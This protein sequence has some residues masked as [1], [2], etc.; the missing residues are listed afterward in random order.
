MGSCPPGKLERRPGREA[1]LRWEAFQVLNPLKA[2]AAHLSDRAGDASLGARYPGE[3]AVSGVPV[4]GLQSAGASD[5]RDAPPSLALAA[6][7]CTSIVSILT[8]RP[9]RM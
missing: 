4:G 8:K 3:G 1:G 7:C 6:L 5:A 2:I 9:H